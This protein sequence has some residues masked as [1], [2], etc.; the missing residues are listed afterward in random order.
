MEET[1]TRFCA[2]IPASLSANSKDVSLSLCLPTPLV[3][4]MRFG[5]IFKPNLLAS[6][7]AGFFVNKKNNT[8]REL[9]AGNFRK[10]LSSM[11]ANAEKAELVLICTAA[12][13]I[14]EELS[15]QF[16]TQPW[17]LERA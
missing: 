7:K 6:K 1:R 3:R 14:A 8:R 4:K 15:R 9:S 5:T 17:R 2:A 16:A 10:T 11:R 12:S 13:A